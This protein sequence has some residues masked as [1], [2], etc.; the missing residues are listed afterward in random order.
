MCALGLALLGGC[1]E[2]ERAS[3]W[4]AA[5]ATSFPAP[6][7][8]LNP[9]GDLLPIAIRLDCSMVRD[10][11]PPSTVYVR[12]GLQDGNAAMMARIEA[13]EL[14]SRHDIASDPAAPAL[15]ARCP[16]RGIPEHTTGRRYDCTHHDIQI[17]LCS[18]G[19]VL[20]SKHLRDF[21]S[22]GSSLE[23]PSCSSVATGD[24]GSYPFQSV[25]YQPTPR[26][27]G[28]GPCP[29]FDPAPPT[30]LADDPT[31]VCPCLDE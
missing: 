24:V 5:P 30:L 27:E 17:D 11:E 13:D 31:F 14:C 21:T 9:L 10:G 16:L 25:V 8:P 18:P 23:K 15:A 19:F 7:K 2:S 20:Q 28:G 3:P 26:P 29:I 4:T 12:I 1:E 6:P 22:C